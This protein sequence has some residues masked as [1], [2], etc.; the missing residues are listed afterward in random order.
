MKKFIFGLRYVIP[1]VGMLCLVAACTKNN[2]TTMT[3]SGQSFI[4]LTNASPSSAIYSV[5]SDSVNL[6]SSSQ[7]AFGVTTGS[8]G[9]PYH[10]I[11]AGNNIIRW[12]ADGTTNVVDTAYNF[13]AGQYYS[14]F[15]YDTAAA[16]APL[17]LLALKDNLNAPVAGI[18]EIRFLSLS[19]NA[20]PSS[21][22]LRNRTD[23]VQLRNTSYIGSTVYNMDSL[24][25]FNIV[26]PG[27]YNVVVNNADNLNLLA[28]TDSVTIVAGKIYTLY[29][30][31]YTGI[32]GSNT[33]NFGLIIQK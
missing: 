20:S 14:F 8:G 2:S 23:T 4:A 19:P 18:A 29:T 12:T 25:A 1:A 32:T 9:T 5:Y 10:T 13:Q 30:R 11:T 3:N 22:L 15:V 16:G 27:T 21:I 6:T 33:F 17:K 26:N 31:G 24:A 7:L 28:N